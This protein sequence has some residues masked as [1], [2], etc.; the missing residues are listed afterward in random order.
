MR[1]EPVK[2]TQ[3][4]EHNLL[5]IYGTNLLAKLVLRVNQYVYLKINISLIE[6]ANKLLKQSQTAPP[7]I[8]CKFDED[9]LPVFF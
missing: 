1:T 3:N 9:Q 6:R 2:R 4:S 8:E 7:D 5:L